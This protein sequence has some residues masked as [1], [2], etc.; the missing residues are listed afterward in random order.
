MNYSKGMMDYLADPERQKKRQKNMLINAFLPGVGFV[1]DAKDRYDFNLEKA[2]KDG[3][4]AASKEYEDKLV[5]QANKF[6]KQTEIFQKEIEEYEELVLAY[7]QEIKQLTSD[8]EHY[9]KETPDS[10]NILLIEDALQE[11]QDV[12]IKLRNMKIE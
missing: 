12:Y 7:E 8:L 5:A 4:N 9:K 1:M 2:G 3:Y 6:F 11:L 10:E